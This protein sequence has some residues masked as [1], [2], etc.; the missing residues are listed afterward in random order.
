[1][2]LL[3]LSGQTLIALA[4]KGPRRWGKWLLR[5]EFGQC[6]LFLDA[7]GPS[8]RLPSS[9][10]VFT[11][12]KG[13]ASWLCP[14]TIPRR[15]ENVN[16]E[17]PLAEIPSIGDLQAVVA[18]K[19][20]HCSFGTCSYCRHVPSS[21]TPAWVTLVS[22]PRRPSASEAIHSDAETHLYERM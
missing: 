21:L 8:G 17:V 4:P 19:G 2:P 12:G 22:V 15:Q 20:C 13:R 11:G 10:N 14:S 7:C 9:R 3:T 1:M 18:S 5:V 16:Q 6:Q